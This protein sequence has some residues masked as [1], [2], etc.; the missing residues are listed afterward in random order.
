MK[1]IVKP[2]KQMERIVKETYNNYIK[3]EK[4]KKGYK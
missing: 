1:R 2:R 4:E 3:S